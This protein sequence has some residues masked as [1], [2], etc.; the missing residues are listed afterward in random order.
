MSVISTLFVVDDAAV[1]SVAH[2]HEVGLLGERALGEGSVVKVLEDHGPPRVTL[3]H[4][5]RL[6]LAVR[7][8]HL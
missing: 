3:D 7:L 4:L 1:V 5:H 8:L 6:S 2:L